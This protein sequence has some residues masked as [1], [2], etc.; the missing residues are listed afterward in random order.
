MSIPAGAKLIA[1]SCSTWTFEIGVIG[2][3][4]CNMKGFCRMCRGSPLSSTCILE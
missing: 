3:D 1:P 2:L 4:G